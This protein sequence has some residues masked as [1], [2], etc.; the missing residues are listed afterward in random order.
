MPDGY[1]LFEGRFIQLR[2]AISAANALNVALVAVPAGKIWTVLAAALYSSIAETQDYWW[3]VAD[4]TNNYNF[5]ITF[6]LEGTTNTALARY[7]PLVTEGTEL[8][9]F[10][11]E[12]LKGYRDAAAVGATLAIAARIIET[13]LP[14]YDYQDQHEVARMNRFRRAIVPPTVGGGGRPHGPL[15]GGTSFVKGP[16]GPRPK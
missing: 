10:P 6:P 8:K 12:I 5:T 1:G 15:I 4:P 7:F 11:G 13:D 16:G 2:T 9:I 3:A 14:F